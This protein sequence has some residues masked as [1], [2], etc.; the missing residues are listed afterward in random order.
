MADAKVLIGI[1]LA[2]AVLC[3]VFQYVA[4]RNFMKGRPELAISELLNSLPGDLD[5]DQAGAL[6]GE[7]ARCFRLKPGMLRLD[8]ALS[9]LVAMDSW[10]LGEGQED[11]ESWLR[12]KGIVNVEKM[13]S[14]VGDLINTAVPTL[15]GSV[16]WRIRWS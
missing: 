14:T 7:V 12:G 11:L 1:V 16:A 8:D 10:M 9:S 3:P 5:R 6:L 4:R 2:V 13:P 15:R